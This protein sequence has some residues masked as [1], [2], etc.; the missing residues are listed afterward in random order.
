MPSLTRNV[1]EGLVT[2]MGLGVVRL[3]PPDLT[4]LGVKLGSVVELVTKSGRHAFAKCY[5]MAA[6]EEDAS[7]ESIQIEGFLRRNLGIDT[8]D[9]VEVRDA[10]E[11]L[12]AEYLLLESSD[13]LPGGRD[14][15][16]ILRSHLEGKPVWR[17]EQVLL[18]HRGKG[19]LMLVKDYRPEAPFVLVTA[20]TEVRLIQTHPSGER[21]ELETFSLYINF[22][23]KVTDFETFTK[24]LLSKGFEELEEGGDTYHLMPSGFDPL[25]ERVSK[26][27]ERQPIRSEPVLRKGRVQLVTLGTQN[28]GKEIWFANRSVSSLTGDPEGFARD[29]EEVAKILDD[30]LLNELKVD[31]SEAKTILLDL[32]YSVVSDENSRVVLDEVKSLDVPELRN[33]IGHHTIN[34]IKLYPLAD[35]RSL[36]PEGLVEIEVSPMGE[37]GYLIRFT[38][39]LKGLGGVTSGLLDSVARKAVEVARALEL[40]RKMG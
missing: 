18:P 13:G 35:D 25:L 34:G 22:R 8:G 33:L 11:P 1:T 9:S 6:K 39:G 29:I 38:Y 3:S 24:L 20:R 36:S 5:F 32:I 37:S 28:F 15:E 16:A 19:R 4:R 7:P 40:C 14:T 31:V 10:P 21:G 26:E 12:L 30:V 23:R 2:D 27:R 17:G